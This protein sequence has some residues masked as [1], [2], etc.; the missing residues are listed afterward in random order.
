MI[1]QIECISVFFSVFKSHVG[2]DG[3]FPRRI[4]FLLS[5][6]FV[7]SFAENLLKCA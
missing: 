1:S 3:R 7:G 5:L 6:A 2:S 4:A